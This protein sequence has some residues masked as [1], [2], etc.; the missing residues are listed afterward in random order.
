MGKQ[1]LLCIPR[2]LHMTWQLLWVP[3]TIK[4]NMKFDHEYGSLIAFWKCVILLYEEQGM[5]A[6]ES[7]WLIYK[8]AKK[9]CI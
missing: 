1:E 9:I 7:K 4:H 2:K 8:L 3:L 6:M 5:P